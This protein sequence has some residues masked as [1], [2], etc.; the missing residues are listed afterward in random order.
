M[1]CLTLGV[2]AAVLETGMLVLDEL[3]DGANMCEARQR[4]GTELLL[5]TLLYVGKMMQDLDV[6]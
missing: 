5:E 1:R 2:G 6:I 3:S 4:R